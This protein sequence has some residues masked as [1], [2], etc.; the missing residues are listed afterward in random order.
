MTAEGRGAAGIENGG[1]LVQSTLKEEVTAFEP[2]LNPTAGLSWF[3]S[4]RRTGAAEIENGGYLVQST[5]KEEVT[6]FAPCLTGQRDCQGSASRYP[7][8]RSPS[9]CSLCEAEA[10]YYEVL[11]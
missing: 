9:L 1:C 4:R 10:E 8:L 5:L 6:A 3:K 7:K 11:A 2:M